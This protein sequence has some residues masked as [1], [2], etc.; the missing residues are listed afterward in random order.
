[1]W[2][3]LGT[4]GGASD[5]PGSACKNPHIFGP[6]THIDTTHKSHMLLG[7]AT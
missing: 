7:F 4:E 3:L 1:M 2:Q 6:H 5:H